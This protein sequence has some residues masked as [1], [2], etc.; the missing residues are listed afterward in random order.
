VTRRTL[1]TD[2]HKP[3]EGLGK[4]V[5][6]VIKAPEEKKSFGNLG[7]GGQEVYTFEYKDITPVISDAV[8]KE[9]AVDEE[10]VE[11]HRKVV[12][13]VMT[14]YSVLPVAYG[15]IFKNRKLLTIAMGAGYAAMKK[16]FEAVDNKVELGIKIFLPKGVED[17]NGK[18]S[19]C[20]SEFLENLRGISVDSKELKLFSD[21]LILNVAF[22]V[23][24]AKILEFSERVG[25]IS[26]GYGEVKVQYSG[27]W[28]AYNFVDIYILGK[29]RKGFR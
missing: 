27:P 9:Y 6:C 25:E 16:A 28:P 24:K 8:F 7:F 2:G 21:R 5:Y 14:E 26:S 4:Y 23:D 15:M 20:R 17:W 29:Q 18:R 22:L 13:R 3:E 19:E 11:T 10:E 1:R 12:E